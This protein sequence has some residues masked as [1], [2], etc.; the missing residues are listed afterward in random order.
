M[1]TYLTKADLRSR[2]WSN[3]LIRNYL[4]APDIKNSSPTK[5]SGRPQQLYFVNRV[6]LIED[7]PAYKVARAHK[8]RLSERM[9]RQLDLKSKQFADIVTAIDLPDMAK[10]YEIV[11]REHGDSHLESRLALQLLLGK[12]KLLDAQLD[13]YV[14]H[15]GICD[16]RSMLKKRILARIIEQCPAL[17]KVAEM[18][19]TVT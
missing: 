5:S 7:S 12:V 3:Q 18:E 10:E 15:S 13:V 8:E 11:L 14:W 4:G 2:G 1:S 6:L 16:A 19:I 9:Q 17:E